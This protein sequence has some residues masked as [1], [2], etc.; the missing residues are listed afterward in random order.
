[1]G[2]VSEFEK[3]K[4]IVGVLYN[5]KIENLFE[6]ILSSLEKKFG[7]ADF[8][9]EP[10]DFCYTNYYDGEIGKP[11]LKRII[12]FEKLIDPEK[13]SDIKIFTNKLE[14]I[15]LK[16]IKLP[17]NMTLPPRPV[18]LDPGILDLSHLILATTKNRGHRVPLKKGIY[19]E[20]TLLYMN[21]AYKK[22]EWT[23]DDFSTDE[24]CNVLSKIREIYRK[25]RNLFL[26]NQAK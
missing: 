15:L 20:L 9:S 13:L 16:K 8:V 23:Y 25:N 5:G 26:K 4:L 17:Q 21:G 7:K 12:S 24:Y 2:S 3:V 18:N 14:Q 1:M 19:C 22:M 6:L 10:M 11:I